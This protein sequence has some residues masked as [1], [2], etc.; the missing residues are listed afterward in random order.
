MKKMIAESL[1]TV[2]TH[3]HTH[4]HTLCLL[5]EEENQSKII[6]KFKKIVIKA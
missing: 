6:Y 4:T 2:H 3:T 1:G 5:N